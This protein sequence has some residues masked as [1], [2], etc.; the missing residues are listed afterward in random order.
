MKIFPQTKRHQD[1]TNHG[2]WCSSPPAEMAYTRKIA[3]YLS[4]KGGF[5]PSTQEYLTHSTSTSTD[6]NIPTLSDLSLA[7]S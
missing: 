6:T 5:L 3:T 4:I 2:A 1:L 7:E